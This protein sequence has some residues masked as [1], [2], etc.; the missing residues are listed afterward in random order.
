VEPVQAE[1]AML[2]NG[3]RSEKLNAMPKQRLSADAAWIRQLGA[4]AIASEVKGQAA[5][6]RRLDAEARV[7][8]EAGSANQ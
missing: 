3:P 2:A 1:D 4:D 7:L 8:A 5:A 6:D